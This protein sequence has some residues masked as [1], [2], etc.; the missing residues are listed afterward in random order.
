MTYS[1]KK[2]MSS[3]S[4]SSSSIQYTNNIDELSHEEQEKLV[5][6]RASVARLSR[7]LRKA[8]V[9]RGM[10]PSS[11]GLVAVFLIFLVSF[12]TLAG[13]FAFAA[14]IPS[15]QYMYWALLDKTNIRWFSPVTLGYWLRTLCVTVPVIISLTITILVGIVGLVTQST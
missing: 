3:S 9:M 12:I 15:H 5:E 14:T 10:T 11:V 4:A 13:G 7:A 2:Q 1:I 6:T 8:P